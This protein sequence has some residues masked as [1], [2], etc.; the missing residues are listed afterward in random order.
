MKLFHSFMDF[1]AKCL[2]ALLDDE[3]AFMRQRRQAAL[4]QKRWV[5]YFS[6]PTTFPNRLTQG[7]ARSKNI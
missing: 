7:G 4:R 3:E 5:D 1:F 6:D 2:E